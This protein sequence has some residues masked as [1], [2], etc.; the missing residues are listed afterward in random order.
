M[1]S[2][3]KTEE[4]PSA[5][6]LLDFQN[7]DIDLGTVVAIRDHMLRCEFCTAEVEFY[8]FYPPSEEEVAVQR[9]PEPLFE[10]AQALMQK[11][12]DLSS[13]N[14]LVLDSD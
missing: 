8:S 1:K 6:R 3:R 11:K 5:E 13:L 2:F 12:A 4:C 7:G 14:R 9:M 10:L